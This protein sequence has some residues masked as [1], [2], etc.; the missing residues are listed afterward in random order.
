MSTSDGQLKNGWENAKI[1]NSEPSPKT[2]N[3]LQIFCFLI[4]E[5]I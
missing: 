4:D 5:N 3:G 1:M 2:I